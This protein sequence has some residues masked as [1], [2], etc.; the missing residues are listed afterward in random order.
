MPLVLSE[1]APLSRLALVSVIVALLP[2]VVND[3]VPLTINAPVCVIPN[4]S[5]PVTLRL[6]PTVDAASTVPVPLTLFVRL[7]SLPE[8]LV[9]SATAPLS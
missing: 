6:P 7:A 4:V 5:R 8:P 3:E 9:L 2:E 1:T